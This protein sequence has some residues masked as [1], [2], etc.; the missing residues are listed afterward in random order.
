MMQRLCLR[1]LLL[2]MQVLLLL[3]VL[4]V[5]VCVRMVVTVVGYRQR[6]LVQRGAARAR[7]G[8]G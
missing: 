5:G 1:M 3:Q 2:V 8:A 7:R 6:Q 4:L